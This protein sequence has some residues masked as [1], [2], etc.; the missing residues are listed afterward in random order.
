MLRRKQ[1]WGLR[2][3]THPWSFPSK[4]WSGP[5]TEQMEGVAS[6]T[7]LP[8]S[9]QP[10]GR[11]RGKHPQEAYVSSLVPNGLSWDHLNI[12]KNNECN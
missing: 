2:K 7:Q 12:K 10:Q 1:E 9:R 5:Y 3:I 8:K 6:P 11:G 4:C